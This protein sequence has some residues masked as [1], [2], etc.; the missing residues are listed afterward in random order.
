M[1]VWRVFTRGN[2]GTLAKDM[3][4]NVETRVHV[5]IQQGALLCALLNFI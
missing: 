4:A 3:P 5:A 1:V 2:H